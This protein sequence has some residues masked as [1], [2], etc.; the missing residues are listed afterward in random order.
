MFVTA[1]KSKRLFSTKN[2]RPKNYNRPKI[3]FLICFWFILSTSN[4][5]IICWTQMANKN[6]NLIKKGGGCSYKIPDAQD[7]IFGVPFVHISSPS[8]HSSPLPLPRHHSL[9]ARK[10][11]FRRDLVKGREFRQLRIKLY[12]DPVSIL[13]LTSLLPD[14][15]GFWEQALSVRNSLAPIR[16]S[17]KCEDNKYY[18]DQ[19]SP[20]LRCVTRCKQTTYCGEVAVPD[21]H[22]FCRFC[23]QSNPLSCVP[24]GPPD[25]QGIIGSDFLLYVSAVPSQRCQ[26]DD[27][28]AYAAHCQQEAELD[29]PIAGHVNICPQA[30]STHSHD[31]EV[32]LSTVKHEILHALG[33]SAG[34]YAFFRDSEGRP[35]SRRNQ[36]SGRPLSF[37]R[38]RGFYDAEA[39]T[40]RTIIREDW[41]TAEGE[42]PHPVHLLVT[43]R[44][45][46]EAR[47]HFN[48]SKL[49]GAELE[50][51]GGDGTSLTH[52]EK[53]LFE[54]EAMTG[55]HTQNPVYSRLTLALMEDSGWYKANYSVAEPLHWGNNLGCDF[56]MKSCGQWIKQRMERNES[57]APFCADIKHDGSKSLATTRCTD[58]R[59]S[60]ALCNLVPHKKELPKQYRNFGKLKGVRK[61]GIKYYGGFVELADY[62]PYN[63]EFEW[64]TI[65]NTSSGRRDSRCELIGNGPPDGE[66]SEEYNEG[67]AILELYGHGS[68]CLDLGLSWTEKKCGRTRTYSQ[69]MA[70]C[71]Q[72]VCLNGRVNIRVHNSTKLYPCYKSGQPIYIRKLVNG[73]IRE[74]QILCP[75]CQQFCSNKN[76][77]EKKEDFCLPPTDPPLN[78]GEIGDDPLIVELPCK[79]Y[80]NYFNI[81]II[82]LFLF[83]KSRAVF[84]SNF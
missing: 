25:G 75:E 24:S 20:F 4:F 30:L 17:R 7:L 11:R 62:C 32:L 22:L 19:N 74:G 15:I 61:E 54:N 58:Q 36:N 53:R 9:R 52:W 28:I 79:A 65:I 78:E 23:I 38:E 2:S 5:F 80:R 63:Q 56:A 29:R 37:N 83:T 13:P 14:A 57:A 60:L 51:Q 10:K 48:C 41:W 3:S 73:W 42:L 71:Y 34:L 39:S 84:F 33:F 12:F 46:E 35:R 55:T 69:F 59:D 66:I 40:V 77:E 64:K 27:T 45:I 68:R 70:G 72:I 49:E 18:S 43:E 67:N 50:N 1:I 16:L 76:F 81:L 26:N 47:K 31:Q 6:F 21:E 8:T 82:F 44:I